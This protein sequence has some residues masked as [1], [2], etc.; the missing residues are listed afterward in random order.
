MEKMPARPVIVQHCFGRL[1]NGG[2]AS[3]LKVVLESELAV[4]YEMKTCFQG[5]PAGGVNL[6]L[7]CEM[8]AQIRSARPDLLHVRGL[9]NEGFHG[10]V[11]GRLA[12][13][14]RIL[15]SVHGSATEIVYPQSR[16]RQQ[17]VARILEPLSL[18]WAD[19]VYC[20]CEYGASRPQV[21]RHAK[22]VFGTIYNAAPALPRTPGAR[23][24]LRNSLGLSIKEVVG[25][26][27]SRITREKG[28]Y[29]LC[30]AL[31]TLYRAGQCPKMVIVGD[32]NE[33]VALQ[34]Y[35]ERTAPGRWVFTGER[36]DVPD[37]LCMSDFFVSASLHENL[38]MAIIEAMSCGLP[39]IATDI[40]GTPEA[41]AHGET[42]LLVGVGDRDALAD[43]VK[44]LA[45]SSG[46]RLCFGQAA[47]ARAELKFGL[48]RMT[49]GL[50]F[51]YSQMLRQIPL[52]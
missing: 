40:G 10:V 22:R 36:Q 31:G 49:A 34:D 52:T 1:F 11:A 38:S 42:G 33:R 15:L 24:R 48:E 13:C 21:L 3:E 16:L 23:L 17:V 19:G 9:G 20:V 6:G 27:V 35:A 28:L 8:A 5:R 50:D 46:L 39:V 25:I 51:V 2:P 4:K 18:R 44:R 26:T 47:R 41:V 32:G 7:I 29:D 14:R 45:T 30:D 43:A 37:L 12:G